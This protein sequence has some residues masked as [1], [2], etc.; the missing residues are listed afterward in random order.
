MVAS[1][2]KS[3]HQRRL[4]PRAMCVE[5]GGDEIAWEDD[6]VVDEDDHVAASVVN[7]HV[8]SLSGPKPAVFLDAV[9][10]G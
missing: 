6:V 10:E 4:A 8:S 1:V 9:L 2:A 7:A 3:E 5:V